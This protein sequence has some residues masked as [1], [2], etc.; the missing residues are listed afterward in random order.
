MGYGKTYRTKWLED[1][2]GDQGNAGQVLSTTSAGISWVDAS[3]LPVSS[4][5]TASGN[6]IYNSN[7]GNVGIGTDSPEAKLDVESEILISGTDPILR[8]ERGDGFNSDVIKIESS[9][10]NLIIGDTSLD[11][12]AIKTDNGE[13]MRI[14]TNGNV[15][16][17]TDAPEAK[18][19]IAAS[20][21]T[22]VDIV[23]FKNSNDIAKAKISLSA[24]SSGELSLIDGNNN[25]NVFVTSN[26]DSYFNGGNVGIGTTSPNRLLHLQSTGDAIMQITS[27][28]GSGA[29]IDLGDVDDVNGG[30][31]VYDSSSNL[32]LNTASTERLRITSS[33]NVGIGTTSPGYKLQVD[34]GNV[35]ITGGS[36]STLFINEN[37]NQLY[38]DENGVVILKA[39][40]NI[41]LHTNS[42]E[43]IRVLN[44]GNV[45]I[46]ASS[47]NASL[48]IGSAVS[49]SSEKL[50]VRGNS[51]ANYVASFEQDHVTGY[52]VLIDTDGTLVGEPALK[53][54]NTN[55]E[56]FYVGSNGNV[57]I[58]TTNPSANLDIEDASGV[59]VDINSSS[60]DGLF[61]FQD[62]GTTKWSMGRDNTQQNFVF[63]NSS[64]LGSN[65]VLTLA[66]STGNVGIGTTSPSEKLTVDGKIKVTA[67]NNA[68]IILQEIG[69]E[70]YEIRAAGSGL[71]FKNDGDNQFALDQT[72]DVMFYKTD[73][74]QG[75]TYKAF[76]GNVGIGTDSPSDNLHV[77]TNENG[78]GVTIQIDSV[79]EGS[80]G[81]LSFSPSTNDSGTPNVWIRGYRGSS[82]DTNYM[83]FGAGGSST[84]VEA[85]RIDSSGKVGIGTTSPAASALLDV[86][87]TTKGVLLPRMSTT[88][89]N[90][91]SSPAEGLTVYNT[92]LSTLCFFNGISWQKVTST[93][94]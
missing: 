74:S 69:Q 37:T 40:D 71:F 80:Y 41:R 91:I 93:A 12:I 39:N 89:I 81:Q 82:Y 42:S 67:T 50:D 23:N 20:A 66:H 46:G 29:Y 70:E 8:M 86:A 43:R 87:S 10:D 36:S 30:R 56:L 94:M 13:A 18:L 83:T 77:K 62:N 3:T 11:E 32:I 2:S 57:G 58:G 38:G 59:T 4:F 35:A 15:G 33:G 44:N 19:D 34:G 63:S 60:G 90:A 6:D 54:Q 73:G 9:T 92:V 17:G 22:N 78:S 16:I 79:T 5:W 1:I 25:T 48:Q 52:G 47:P 55:S 72:G 68:S 88:Q 65:N 64:S 26:G 27:A 61:R 51:S 76:S 53:I 24:N 85:M 45:G 14:D 28:N 31:I 21:T 75:L 84:G 49:T 7:S